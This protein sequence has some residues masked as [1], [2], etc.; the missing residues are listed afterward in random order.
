M[1]PLTTLYRY[2]DANDNLL[3]VGITDS[4]SRRAHQHQK[5]SQWHQFAVRADLHHYISR[6]E[7]LEAES[8][9]IAQE[10]PYYNIAGSDQFSIEPNKHWQD[11]TTGNLQDPLHQEILEYMICETKLCMNQ[12]I[13]K[14]Q[15]I[16]F[17]VNC[18]WDIFDSKVPC[19][20]CRRLVN[21]NEFN[22][23]SDRAWLAKEKGN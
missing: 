19:V 21:S 17:F 1:F 15:L 10:N 9:A 2:Y 14:D 5:N 3:Y 7:A 12:G 6:E 23:A 16:Y 11:L 13:S 8:M 20:A 22:E 18:I 4:I